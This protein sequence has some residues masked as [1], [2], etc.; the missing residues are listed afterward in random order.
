MELEL[1]NLS[2]SYDGNKVVKTINLK[3]TA[4]EFVSFLGPSG[5]GKTTTLMMISGLIKP[6]S[7]DILF[8]GESVLKLH[9][10]DRNVG[11]VFQSYALYPH[12]TVF[13]NISFSL[14]LKKIPISE[15]KIRVAKIAEMLQITSLLERKPGQLSG[16]QQQRVSIG[17]ALIKEPQMLLF[18]EPLSNLDAALRIRLRAEIRSLQRDLGITSLYVTHDQAE[19]MAIADRIV[20]M[21]DGK[22]VDY[23][24]PKNL[25]DRPKS[26]TVAQFIGVPSM[27]LLRGTIVQRNGKTYLESKDLVLELDAS[28]IPKNP[29]A[30]EVLLGIRPQDIDSSVESNG[31]RVKFDNQIQIVENLGRDCLVTTRVGQTRITCYVQSSREVKLNEALPFEFKM[32]QAQF[33]DLENGN[34]LLWR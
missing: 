8:S 21:M 20:L 26:L 6:S 32:N 29:P 24:S 7:G 3:I 17:R 1:K 18:D 28:R 34:S 33:F 16:G 11:M 14:K 5:C 13:E 27:N 19:A 30:R 9:P 22:V 23:D 15:R 31:G 10:K 4:G 2:K 25:H 12:M